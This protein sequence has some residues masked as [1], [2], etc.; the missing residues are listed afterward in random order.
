MQGHHIEAVVEGHEEI[1]IRV[2]SPHFFLSIF[3]SKFT[4]SSLGDII[5]NILFSIFLAAVCLFCLPDIS[6]FYFFG[7][8]FFVLIYYAWEQIK[9]IVLMI[10][11][12]GKIMN[13]D[14]CVFRLI[15]PIVDWVFLIYLFIFHIDCS[16]FGLVRIP[17]GCKTKYFNYSAIIRNI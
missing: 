5:T 3:V 16:H 11:R 9:H 13:E 17:I 4:P 15:W 14:T 6:P 2:C 10:W 7:L 8:L 12:Q 1:V